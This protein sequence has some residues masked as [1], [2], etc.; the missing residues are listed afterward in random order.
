MLR[1]YT[2]EQAER[3][4][5]K[6]LSAFK[7]HYSSESINFFKSYFDTDDWFFGEKE[8]FIYD[9][10]SKKHF[11]YDFTNLKKR[12]IVE[13][14]GERFHPNPKVL[15]DE[16][17]IEWKHIYTKDSSD[18]VLQKDRYKRNLA[19]Q[20]SFRYFEIYSNDSQEIIDL[21]INQIKELLHEKI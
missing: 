9:C 4:L 19:E 6:R 3:L 12:V 10:I 8:W 7:R 17:M 21:T 2:Q 14:H 15:T 18:R 11:F 5:D 13:Y 1:G 20:N 16:E